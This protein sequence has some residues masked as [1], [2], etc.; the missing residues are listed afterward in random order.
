MK[1]IESVLKPI[2][3]TSKKDRC[4]REFFVRVT[5]F[6]L[7]RVPDQQVGELVIGHHLDFADRVNVKWPHARLPLAACD[8]GYNKRP[9]GQLHR[10]SVSH[11]APYLFRN[12]DYGGSTTGGRVMSRRNGDGD[13]HLFISPAERRSLINPLVGVMLSC[14]ALGG[15][16]FGAAVRLG[17]MT[18]AMIALGGA[19]VGVLAS[20][21][22]VVRNLY[23]NPGSLP[24]D[25]PILLWYAAVL[26]AVSLGMTGYAVW[27]LV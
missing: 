1:F 22:T 23:A 20:G 8:P 13:L 6:V 25:R 2:Q 19:F 26:L 18:P 9:H 15:V 3:L 27:R 7:A 17:H 24:K 12:S 4:D 16:V 11:N 5:G 10:S 14:S 21:I